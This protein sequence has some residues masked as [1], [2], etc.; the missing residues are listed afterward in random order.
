MGRVG[1]RTIGQTIKRSIGQ[2]E[3]QKLDQLVSL[4]L[5]RSAGGFPSIDRFD[6]SRL[7]GPDLVCL[8]LE[9]QLLYLQLQIHFSV[10][11]VVFESLQGSATLHLRSE[12]ASALPALD[13]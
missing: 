7:L 1:K 10:T 13:P 6:R 3:P 11:R 9:G 4:D 5:S 2:S 8:G 12:D